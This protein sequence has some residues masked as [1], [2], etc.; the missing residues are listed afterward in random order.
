LL[1]VGP[2]EV[3]AFLDPL[4]VRRIWGIGPVAERR[5]GRLGVRTIGDLARSPESLLRPVLG[6]FSAQ[7]A[8]LARGEDTREVEPDREARSI[9]EENTFAQDMKSRRA[10]EAALRAHAEAVARRLRRAGLCAEG[11][12]IKVKLARR[13]GPGRFPVLTRSRR[14]S[15]PTDDGPTLARVACELLRTL[16]LSEPVRLVGVAGERLAPTATGQLGLLPGE[17]AEARRQALNRALDG[18]RERFGAGA[19]VR[20]PLAPQRAG[21]SLGVKR[22]ED[23]R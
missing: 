3:R 22:G 2:S 7:A 6:G 15:S 5:L 14:L 12:R 17:P 9:G 16:A 19:L 8:E 11:V 18:I 20:G 4:P 23:R 10:L 21:L 1:V 13:L